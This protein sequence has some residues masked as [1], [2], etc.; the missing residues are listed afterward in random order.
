MHVTPLWLGCHPERETWGDL[1]IGPQSLKH[2]VSLWRDGF[3]HF[4]CLACNVLVCFIPAAT[5]KCFWARGKQERVMWQKELLAWG[6]DWDLALNRGST[7]D[8]LQQTS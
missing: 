6:L 8:K 2:G 1:P 4:D 5:Y 3:S 7:A